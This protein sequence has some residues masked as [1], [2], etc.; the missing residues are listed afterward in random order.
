[1]TSVVAGVED[2]EGVASA[3]GEVVGMAAK[4]GEVLLERHAVAGRPAA[5]GVAGS[6]ADVLDAR[7]PGG[8]V[9]PVVLR[10]QRFET[11]PVGGE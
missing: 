5:V 10:A 6:G 4:V 2:G 9:G 8:M 11:E 7:H 3:P 1:M